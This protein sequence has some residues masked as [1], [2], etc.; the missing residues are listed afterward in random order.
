MS[1]DEERE[2]NWRWWIYIIPKGARAYATQAEAGRA[3][4]EVAISHNARVGVF[5][6]LAEVEPVKDPGAVNIKRI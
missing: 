6:L 4:I 5:E 3:A 1:D 2:R